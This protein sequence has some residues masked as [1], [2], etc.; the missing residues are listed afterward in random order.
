MTRVSHL[1]VL[2]VAGAL[3]LGLAAQVHAGGIVFWSGGTRVITTR[4]PVVTTVPVVT[5]TVP[6][7]VASAYQTGYR[8]GYQD[9]YREGVQDVAPAA[10]VVRPA[11]VVTYVP[12][13]VYQ[14][15]SVPTWT[16]IPRMITRRVCMPS[17]RLHRHPRHP[18]PVR[19]AGSHVTFRW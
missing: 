11:P 17:R 4:T 14:R 9:G 3:V 13:V 10:Y 8:D 1:A 18:W 16:G 7:P 6:A 5:R 15:V 12:S 2:A 19:R